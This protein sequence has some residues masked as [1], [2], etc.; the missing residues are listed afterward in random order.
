M[1][2]LLGIISVASSMAL[3]VCYLCTL[4]GP[5]MIKKS[6]S[7]LYITLINAKYTCLNLC[8]T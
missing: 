2:M 6:I 5:I 7:I 8:N 3:G 4:P 1:K